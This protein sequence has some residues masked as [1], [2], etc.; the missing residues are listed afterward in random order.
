VLHSVW[1]NPSPGDFSIAFSVPE[2][3]AGQ[4]VEFSVTDLLGREV[5]YGNMEARSGYNE[6]SWNKSTGIASGIYSII[7]KAGAMRKQAR[8]II[9]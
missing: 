1:P 8:V 7:L 4:D 9:K 6:F 3:M 5:R 2:S